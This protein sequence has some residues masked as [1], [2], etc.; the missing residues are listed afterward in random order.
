LFL[1][2]IHDKPDRGFV[3]RAGVDGRTRYQKLIE[4]Q[5]RALATADL[6]LHAAD[7][8]ISLGT[9]AAGLGHDVNNVLLPVRARLNAIEHSGLTAV[10]RAHLVAV[11]SSIDYLQQISDGL[12]LLSRD[13]E[14]AASAAEVTRTN[15]SSWWCQVGV[16]LRRAVPMHVRVEASLPAG[17]PVVRI[18]PHWL[19]HAM[20]NLM[21][22]AGEAIPEAR[23][24]ALVRIVAAET[25]DGRAVRVGVTD[26]GHGMSASV[27]R[28]AFDLFFSTKPGRTNGGLGLPLARQALMRA[29]GSLEIESKSG[30]GTSA[31]LIL[32]VEASTG[33]AVHS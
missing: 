21:V 29:G 8:L 24:G 22:N 15:L 30:R 31:V 32:P 33:R 10:T 17:L 23:R 5:T 7:R 16:L 4:Q 18:A 25:S 13:P 28:R 6:R 20:L 2:I 1:A 26:N 12:R 19:T 14:Q 3:I 11:R 27:R 9:L